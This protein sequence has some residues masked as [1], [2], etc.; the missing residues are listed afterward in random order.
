MLAT[1]VALMVNILTLMVE[2]PDILICRI[3]L[4][5]RT[6]SAYKCIKIYL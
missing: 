4:M 1:D 6:G 3:E 2:P 5:Q